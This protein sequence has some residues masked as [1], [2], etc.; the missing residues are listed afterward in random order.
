MSFDTLAPYY[1]AMEAVAAGG[2][3][4]RCRTA[5]L[6]EVSDCRQALLLGEGPGKFLAELLQSNP[7]VQITCVERSPRMIAEARR[8]LAKHEL[9]GTRVKFVP[10]DA[11]HWQPADKKFDLV[12]THFF[13]DCFRSDELAG[14]ITRVAAS[15]TA[16][17]RWLHTDFRVPAHGWRR[18]R[19]KVLLALMYTF[20][21]AA[22]GLSASQLTPA[23]DF[24]RAAG[25]RLVKRRLA[26]F[27]LAHA[28]VWLK[29]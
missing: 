7:R 12:T 22:T 17:A 11:L 6:D 20:F 27:G 1:R 24:L 18:W 19:A 23:D 15:T 9:N 8:Q 28:D 5:Y 3:M 16:Q 4:Q 13:L 14:L 21:R 10:A 29:Q 26:N 2:I 25:F